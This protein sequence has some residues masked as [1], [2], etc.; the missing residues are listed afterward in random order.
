[1]AAGGVIF[2]EG[3]TAFMGADGGLLEDLF[4]GSGGG[5]ADLRSLGG[6]V[7]SEARGI[8]GGA[9]GILACITVPQFLQRIGWLTQSAGIRKTPLQ[10]GHAACTTCAMLMTSAAS[11]DGPVMHTRRSLS[12][13]SFSGGTEKRWD[14][15]LR[16]GTSS[17]LSYI[18]RRGTRR[19][20]SLKLLTILS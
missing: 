9:T 19:N 18:L 8:G 13:W 1:L 20:G 7:L 11:L 2:I 10:P 14:G 3:G 5:D 15:R 17:S 6:G 12:R 16:L 4:C